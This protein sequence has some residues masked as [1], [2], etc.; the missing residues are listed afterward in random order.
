MS[1][2]FSSIEDDLNHP[3]EGRRRQ[4]GRTWRRQP[5]GPDQ[6]MASVQRR[7]RA[8]GSEPEARGKTDWGWPDRSVLLAV[9]LLL[10]PPLGPAARPSAVPDFH[11]TPSARPHGRAW[12]SRPRCGVPHRG[13]G[14]VLG[15]RVSV[16][17]KDLLSWRDNATVRKRFPKR[18]RQN[19]ENNPMHSSPRLLNQRLARAPFAS[20][21]QSFDASGK[22]AINCYYSEIRTDVN[23]PLAGFSSTLA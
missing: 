9:R 14:A 8:R 3:T 16:G 12:P 6:R 2:S 22:T 18:T 17:R 11:K 13:P 4:A 10:R 21:Q 7:P 23:C 15:S 1:P 20:R 5:S 19:I